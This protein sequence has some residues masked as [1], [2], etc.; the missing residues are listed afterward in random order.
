MKSVTTRSRLI[1]LGALLL[2]LQAC[3]PAASRPGTEA[4]SGTPAPQ[5]QGTSAASGQLVI[6][7]LEEPG[8]L[9][10]MADL[11][12]HFPQHVPQTLLF[13]NLTQFMPDGS[14]TA[15]L[16]ESWT[17]SPDNL[18]YTFTLAPNARF[19]DGR[20]V[21]AEDVKFTFDAAVDP[22]TKSSD[23]GLSGVARTEA[24]DP[25]TVRVT[26][27][28]LN[29]KFLAEGGARG[30][31]P[32]HLLEGKDLSRDEFNKKPVGSGPYKLVAYTPGQ[33]V[34]MDAVPDF[35]R[36]APAIKRVVF[37]VLTDQNVILTQLRS[38]ELQYALITPR[39]LAAVQG[40]RS[41]KVVEAK[42]PRF[43]DIAPNYQRPFWQDAR[44][45][46]AVLT[47]IDRKGIVDKV[48]L[49]HGQVVEAN[50][51]PVSWAFNPGVT[52][53]PYNPAKARAL[54][55]EA[56][57]R[58]TPGGTRQKDDQRLAFTIMLN[59]YDR[60]LEQALIVAQQNLKD[61]GVD[62]KLERVDPGVFGDR[63]GKKEYDALSRIWNP[64]YDPDQ[65]GLVASGNF[66]GYSN[67]RV[68]E[69]STQA[70]GTLDR[71]ARK[72]AYFEV[73]ELVARDVVRLFLYSENELHA[74]AAGLT[75]VQPHP[76][77]IFWNIKDWRLGT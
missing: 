19:H 44:V 50:V 28:G 38:G 24:V 18:V 48:L 53:H 5:A 37:K 63:Q 74:V 56:G 4:G 71:E 51:S 35:Y 72:R 22:A 75:G 60:T 55:D 2:V 21:T 58:P 26:L 9:S 41:L 47:A 29:P 49:G 77:N 8:S 57:W 68:D 31:V 32:K 1:V 11:P 61:V 14:V 10:A 67:P 45:R 7:S 42:T 69:L 36:G 39:D 34:V 46:E 76:V 30:I 43:F 73:Q 64:V 20:P 6:G 23:E 70:F 40:M 25:R 62:V 27:K 65:G 15:K 16:A 17:V 66:Y 54:L 52:Q 59:N 12:H 3:V 33:S 13:D